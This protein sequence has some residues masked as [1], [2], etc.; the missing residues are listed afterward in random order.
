MSEALRGKMNSTQFMPGS[1][2]G[3]VSC[4]RRAGWKRCAGWVARSVPLAVSRTG[5]LAFLGAAFAAVLGSVSGGG[6]ALIAAPPKAEQAEPQFVEGGPDPLAVLRGVRESQAA[7]RQS[8]NGKLR[9]GA[10]K[11]P[12]KMVMNGGELRFEFPEAR[13]PDPQA[14]TLSFGAKDA[15]VQVQSTTGG[16]QRAQFGD[17]IAGMGV[18]YEDLAM[19]F[20]YWNKAELEGE[21]RLLP[22]LYLKCWRIRVHRP[23]GVRSVYKEVVVWVSQDNGGILKSEAYDDKGTLVRRLKV[24]SIQGSGQGTTLKQMRIESPQKGG[25]FVYLD[26]DGHPTVKLFK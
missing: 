25:D 9:M 23:S 18:L 5:S 24:V 19:R 14:V 26:V 21:E 17:E 6:C 4:C 16:V 7:I 20:L 13:A 15:S 3:G 8:L 2:P 11:L 22:P 1:R 12:Y 10:R